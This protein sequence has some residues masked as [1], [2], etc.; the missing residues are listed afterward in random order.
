L[1]LNPAFGDF[2]IDQIRKTDVEDWLTRAAQAR[3]PADGD[4]EGER[5]SPNS[6]MVQP[7]ARPTSE[8]RRTSRAPG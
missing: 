8:G 6:M 4:R 7:G 1:R 2:F 5:Y 3:K